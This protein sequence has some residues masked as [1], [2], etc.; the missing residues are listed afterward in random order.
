MIPLFEKFFEHGFNGQVEACPACDI[1]LRAAV[2][3]ANF[4]RRKY[5]SQRIDCIDYR[6]RAWCERTC[7]IGQIVELERRRNDLL[8]HLPVNA[9]RDDS[10]VTHQHLFEHQFLDTRIERGSMQHGD[11]SR[12]P[13]EA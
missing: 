11:S 1:N 5:L 6:N 12:A 13:S 10:V 7:E 9:M 8:E 3:R 4:R 2:N